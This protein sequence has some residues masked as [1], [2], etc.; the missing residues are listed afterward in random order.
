MTLARRSLRT[1]AL[2]LVVFASG[3]ALDARAPHAGVAHAQAAPTA[4]ELEAAKKAYGE[5]AKL[6]AAEKYGEAVERFKESYRL[7]RNPVLLYNIGLTF[8]RLGTKDMALFYYKKFL[9]DAPAEA[10]QRPDVDKSVKQLEKDGATEPGTGDP[11]TGTGDVSTGDPGTGDVGTGDPGTGTGDPV[12]EDPKPKRTGP[13]TAEDFEHNVVDEAP[14]GTP[15]DLTASVPDEA[16]WTV[17]LSYRG[18]GDDKFTVVV[19]KP[20]YKELVGRIPAAKMKGNAVQYFVEVKNE[21][22][23]LITR[24]GKST[25]PN[26]VYLDAA[27]APRYYPDLDEGATAGDGGKKRTNTLTPGDDEDPLGGKRRVAVGPGPGSGGSD[28]PGGPGFTDVGSKKFGYAKW[29]ATGVGAGFLTLS[30]TFYAMASSWAGSLEA[31]AEVSRDECTEPPCRAYDDERKDLEATGERYETISQIT[32]AVGLTGAVVAGYFWYKE[33]TS[34]KKSESGAIS[35]T[36][37]RGL[38]SLVAS[39]VVGD[40]FLGGAAALRF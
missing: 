26:V 4:E 18:A 25:S 32:F 34:S 11:G 27:A 1:I 29:G 16:G 24:I 13:F 9:K 6:F 3:V 40:D 30:L 7:S 39:P 17:S 8:E 38:R 15:L 36:A 22:G 28:S 19:M 12:V 14:P 10:P 31:E 37:S 23:E 33:M 20:R 5:G 35:S 2:A 21:A